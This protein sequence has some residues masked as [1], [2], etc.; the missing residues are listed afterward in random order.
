MTIKELVE[1]SEIEYAMVC[2]IYPD[3][4]KDW[5]DTYYDRD[6][7]LTSKLGDIPL[8]NY[9]VRIDALYTMYLEIDYDM[10]EDE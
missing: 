7:L 5:K 9:K 4:Y 8:H 6:T 10:L 2:H 3:G 1:H